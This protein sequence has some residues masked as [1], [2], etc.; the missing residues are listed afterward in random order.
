[1][2]LPPL[3]NIGD[4]APALRVRGWVKGEPVERFEKG[5]V[6]VLEFWATWCRPC[7]A[8]MP[9]LSALAG[10]YKDRVTF[11][12]IDVYEKKTVG[13]IKAFVDSMG[14]RMDFRVAA[15][16]SDLMVAGWLV[17]TGGED[18]WHSEDVCGRWGGEACLDGVSY[19]VG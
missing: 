1:M 12:G 2:R 16:D 7:I 6:Y 14:K 11:L 10:E 19:R 4:P 3:L 9:H 5:K 8:A 13:K 15:E 18:A 17:D